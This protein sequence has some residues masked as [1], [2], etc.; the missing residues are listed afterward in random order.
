MTQ[1]KLKNQVVINFI[2]I[3]SLL[4]VIFFV[5]IIP[6]LTIKTFLQGIILWATKILPALLPFFILTK[7]ISYTSFTKTTGKFLS[8]IT[9]KLYG[10][11]G[12]SGYIFL[13][14]I[15]SGYPV[16]AKLTADLYKNGY[17]TSRQAKTITSFT[18]T[19]G[20]LFI[21]GTVGI[22]FFESA[23]TGVIILISHF[24]SALLNG[25]LYRNKDKST[26]LNNIT[27]T[28]PHN[29]I[30]ESMSNSI[31]SILVVGGFIALFY[32]II[33]LLNHLQ[34]FYLPIKLFEIIGV[35]GCITQS[36]LSGMIEVTTGISILSKT[37]I[38]SKLATIISSFLVSF[39]GFSIH[40]Q[41]YCFLKDFNMKY[42]QFLIQKITHALISASVTFLIV[43]FI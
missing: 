37:R 6:E 42:S 22:G 18:S 3:S 12:A 15:I 41:A 11:G 4:L 28:P 1:N 34:V 43:L 35:D 9:N 7:L 39:G 17:F 31:S 5:A 32:M 8:P 26:M 30:H 25:L 38:S 29:A 10:V 27:D 19:S 14:S 33:N 23:Q 16:G 13:M 40:A 36:V 20:P 2:Y 21:I 24:I